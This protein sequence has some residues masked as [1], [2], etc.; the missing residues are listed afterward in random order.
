MTARQL[1]W[2]WRLLALYRNYLLSS[3]ASFITISGK[4][5][6][7]DTLLSHQAERSENALRVEVTPAV[8]QPCGLCFSEGV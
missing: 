3:H 2:G 7:K 5:S 4:T 8:G 1:P 6:E